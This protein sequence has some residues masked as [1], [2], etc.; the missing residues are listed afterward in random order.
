M[1]RAVNLNGREGILSVVSSSEAEA[2]D[3]RPHKRPRRTLVTITFGEVDLEGMSQSHDDA[4]V[5]TSRIGG[6]LVKKVMIDQG[7]GAEIV[8]LNIY[9]GLG[10]KS[11]DL[12]KYDTPLMGFDGKIVTLEG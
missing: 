2:S 1:S 9:K 7:S 6:F 4:L 11:E 8:Y 3:R 10:L 5:M 12:S